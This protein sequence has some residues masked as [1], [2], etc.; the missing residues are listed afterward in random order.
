MPFA[1]MWM[2][3]EMVILNEISQK[4]SYGISYGQNLNYDTNELTYKIDSQ[5]QKI[6][7]W[8]PRVRG[9]GEQMD[10]E[11]GISR[12][13]LLSLEWINKALPHSTENYIQYPEINHN[14]KEYEKNV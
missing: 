11:F 12:C 4:S 1:A 5:T 7:L 13:K 3:L 14:E 10:S 8:L 6:D 2:D 9:D